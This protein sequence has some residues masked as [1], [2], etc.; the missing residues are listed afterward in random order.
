MKRTF[1]VAGLVVASMAGGSAYAFGGHKGGEGH[2]GERGKMRL[3]QLDLNKDGKLSLEELQ[4]APLKRFEQGDTNGDGKIT[5]EEAAAAASTRAQKRFEKMLKRRDT[6]KDGA[7]SQA[8]MLDTARQAEMFA[9]LDADKD[10]FLSQDEMR[11]MRKMHKMGK[12]RGEGKT[13]D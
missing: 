9:E 2:G 10:G 13:R 6:D 7:L 8:E 12:M 11:K 5:A 4:A 3:E 1:I